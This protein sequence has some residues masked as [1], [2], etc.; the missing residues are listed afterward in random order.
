M[1]MFWVGVVTL[2][3]CLVYYLLLFPKYIPSL[4]GLWRNP[5][6]KFE[7]CQFWPLYDIL[8]DSMGVAAFSKVPTY[9][10]AAH[11]C[12]VSEYRCRFGVTRSVSEIESAEPRVRN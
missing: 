6:S 5:S 10:K 2:F 8:E 3:Y 4:E 11:Y 1:V 9:R 12:I 7:N